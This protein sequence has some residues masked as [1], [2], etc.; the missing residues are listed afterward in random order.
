[1]VILYCSDCEKFMREMEL[2]SGKCPKHLKSRKLLVIEVKC[3]GQETVRYRGQ[4]KG[5]PDIN[6]GFEDIGKKKSNKFCKRKFTKK[7]PKDTKK[8][9]GS[10]GLQRHCQ[11]W[12]KRFDVENPRL[13]LEHLS[14][15]DLRQSDEVTEGGCERR[16]AVPTRWL[17]CHVMLSY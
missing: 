2:R 13:V 1:M 7:T 9:Y 3:A 12:T 11:V 14:N 8:S 15:I 4:R 17:C 5:S 16:Q 6:R 10:E